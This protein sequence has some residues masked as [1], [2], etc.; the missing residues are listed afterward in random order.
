MGYSPTPPPPA[1]V[2]E[3][4]DCSC[5]PEAPPAGQPVAPPEASPPT[6]ASVT[7]LSIDLTG[8]LSR[9][10]NFSV[11]GDVGL[12]VPQVSVDLSSGVSGEACADDDSGSTSGGISIDVGT[13]SGSGTGG[14]D[15]MPILSLDSET[16]GLV[17][18][19]VLG[20]NGA[21]SDATGVIGGGDESVPLVSL[22]SETDGVVTAPVFGEDGLISSST[23]LGGTIGGDDGLALISLDGE[24]DALI[25]APLLGENGIGGTADFGSLLNAAMLDVG[26]VGSMNSLIGG[27][28]Y[29][30]NI[31]L[32]G[33]D[34]SSALGSTLDLLTTTSSLF[35]VPALDI[36]G[37]DGL[38]G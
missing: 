3:L 32:A 26:N 14:G 10:S 18:V 33:D 34:L 12:T 16:D 9:L 1:I 13:S 38:D 19:P 2:P 24:T 15:G 17:H 11:D 27:D 6:E 30:G 28:V 35:D 4:P 8:L 20:E 37:G 21:L 23:D 29:D 31:P 36:L 22:D 25:N 7:S 5:E